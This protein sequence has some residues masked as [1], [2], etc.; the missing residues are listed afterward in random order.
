MSP[1]EPESRV[2]APNYL[3]NFQKPPMDMH[4]SYTAPQKL[5]KEYTYV[6][7]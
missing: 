1:T 2:Y 4:T 6:K 3:V 5:K 7:G